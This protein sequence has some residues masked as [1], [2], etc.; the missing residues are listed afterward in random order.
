[1]NPGRN[2]HYG[3]V[4]WDKVQPGQ[5]IEVDASY[6]SIC[7]YA[8]KKLPGTT[9]ASTTRGAPEGKRIVTRLA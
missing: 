5:S 4:P 2:E 6:T 7:A 9:W 1:M 3:Y 8:S